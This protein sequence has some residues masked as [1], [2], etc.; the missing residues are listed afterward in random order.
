MPSAEDYRAFELEAA[1]ATSVA[2]SRTVLGRLVTVGVPVGAAVVA[3]W[4][5]YRTTSQRSTIMTAPDK[6]EFTTTQFPAPSLSTPRPQTDQGTIVIPQAPV[7]PAAPPPAPPQTIHPPP[8]PEPPFPA[9]MPNDDE[10]RRL[11]ELERQRLAEEERRKWE[12]LRASQVISDNSATAAG[13]MNPESASGPA[14]AAD[15]DPNRRFLA[16][17]S[18]AGVDVARAT[19]N[20]R[21]DALVAQGTMIR[22]VLETAV[23]SDLPGM[24]RAVVAE[25]V[26]SFDG[27]RIL[28][29]AGSRLVGEY[30]S[31][32]T[33][34][35][36][37]VFV[38]W[39]R[40]LRSDGVSVQLGS[41]GTDDLGR[42]GSAGTV[43]NHYLERFGAAIMLSLV[44]GA[45]QFLSGFGQNYDM[46]GDGTVIT[47]TDPATGMVTQTQTGFGQNQLSLQ[48]RQI[49][50]QNVSQTL[51]NI[52]QEALK[53]SIN[54]PP[55]I[56]LDQGT[57]IMVFV[58]RDLD[59]SSLYPDP[60]KEALREL[61]RERTIQKSHGLP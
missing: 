20:N 35:Q 23:Q 60:V 21:I 12:R 58:R 45:A 59:F 39:T 54:I 61:R 32:L 47:T 51:T 14:A 9:A 34:G 16:S 18:A 33:R 56:H 5:I 8:A 49:A 36:T 7:E 29:P 31:G 41:N 22:G 4:L 38:V 42:A 10:A 3:G 17:V 24:V 27:R 28:I 57:R 52:A 26:W 53:N 30:K 2:R 13:A 48:A 6:E 40:L 44:G 19:R 11:A 1:A 37:R 55:M 15:D 50:A 25:N 43:D 46:T